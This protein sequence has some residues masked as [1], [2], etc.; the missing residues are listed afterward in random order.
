MSNQKV[1]AQMALPPSVPFGVFWRS[2]RLNDV[3]PKRVPTA[4]YEIGLYFFVL[5]RWSPAEVDGGCPLLCHP[6]KK[7]R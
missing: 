2:T 1:P 3:E 7:C 5:A 4:C 6:Q